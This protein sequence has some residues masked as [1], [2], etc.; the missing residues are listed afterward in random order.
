MARL[1][2][3]KEE[4]RWRALR[5]LT[6]LAVGIVVAA[7]AATILGGLWLKYAMWQQLPTIDGRV[8][9]PG[10]S[11]PVT[12]RRDEHGVPHIEA[13]T[14]D[15]LIEAQGFVVAQDR[16]WQMDMARRFSSGEL[17][18]ILGP[19]LVKHD[20]LERVLQ[21]RSTAERLTATMPAEQR[22]H[23]EDYARGVNAFIASHR[24]S[25]PAE[26]RLLDYQPKPWQPVDS[27]LAALGMVE[28][29]DSFYG[30][31]LNRELIASKL[32]P[33]LVA[34]LYP[35]TTW[36]D[37]P[38]TQS[39]PDL[40]APQQ[41]IPEAPPDETTPPGQAAAPGI[42]P[43]NPAANGDDL[44]DLRRLLGLADCPLCRPGSNEWVV[45]GA[46]TASGKPL[47]AND[48]HLDHSIPDVWHEEDLHAGTFHVAGVTSPGIP[49]IIAGH[50]A[51][52]A[53][54]FTSLY[55]DVQD[56]YVEKTNAQG[57]YWSNNG[58]REPEH[59]GEHIRV[60]GSVD[61]TLDLERTEHGPVITPLLPHE[62]R[63]LALKWT[64]Y[65]SAAR[66]LRLEQLDAADNWEDFRDAMSGWWEPTL[67][68]VYA[69]DQGHI[70]YQAA[71]L[72]PIRP[73]GLSGVPIVETGTAADL[74]HEWQG[75]V[76]FDQLPSV[77]DPADGILAT[78]NSRIT[79]DGSPYPLT[80]NWAEP[81]RNE[82]IWKWLAGKEKLTAADMLTLQTDT[83]SEVDQEL[84]QRFAYAI[85]HASKTDAKLRRAADFLRRW[86]GAVSVNSVAAEIVAATKKALWPLILEPKLGK[87][88]EL[89]A[90]QDKS[91]AQEEMVANVSPDWLP[92]GYKSWNDLIASAA[93]KG[94][95]DD[96][97]PLLLSNWT[98]GSRHVLLIKHPLYGLLP[99]FQ[100]W[101]STG[102]HP[103]SGDETTVDQT[104]GVLGPSQRFIMDWNDVDGSSENIFMGESGDPVSPNYRNHF[105]YWYSGKTFALPFTDARV[106]AAAK[107]TLLLTP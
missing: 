39:L 85:D 20:E 87:D 48:M 50:N 62:H 103:L 42:S 82:R 64:V 73:A 4:K 107:H 80:L 94:M 23:F 10:L 25:L 41:N 101:T 13:A 102:P 96:H 16:L 30:D 31:K 21:I 17:A 15:D 75:W 81:Y 104:R 3:Y 98:Y 67:N 106:D 89:Y 1:E 77:L 53:W 45:S 61:V 56:V 18:E 60:R 90:W 19:A 78:A 105:P 35:S 92:P 29:L 8:E 34:Q 68:V 49:L 74:Q 70:G 63:M 26:F 91:F 86:D 22:Q 54:G 12:V 55:G 84:A 76:P 52:I 44:L 7:V 79:P 27:W 36:R 9:L 38:P 93:K 83:Y 72:F 58:W 69:D 71:G 47:L 32:K 51:H 5:I 57:E 65:D 11:A 100:G 28:R 6:M 33:N 97:A 46:R 88:W 40:T 2:A 37:H 66:G 99:Y 24:Q 95:A 59:V 14:L 43:A